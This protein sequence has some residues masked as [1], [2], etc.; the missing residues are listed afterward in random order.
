MKAIT[1]QLIQFIRLNSAILL[2]PIIIVFVVRTVEY[3]TLPIDSNSLNASLFRSFTYSIEFDLIFLANFYLLS[4]I[5]FLL[6]YL[7][8][9]RLFIFFYKVF[10]LLITFSFLFLTHFFIPV[11]F[12][13][14]TPFFILALVNCFLLSVEKLKKSLGNIFGFIYVHC[15]CLFI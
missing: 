5:P 12:Y 10:L 14:I 8:S 4:F 1:A 6:L 2:L 9:K 13:L 11:V 3:L 7:I 15:L